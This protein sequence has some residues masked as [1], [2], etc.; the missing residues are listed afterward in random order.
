M[1]CFIAGTLIAIETGFAGIESIKPGDLVL[2][3]NADTMESGYK[4][5]LKNMYERQELVHIIAG[6]EESYRHRIIQILCCRKR[7]LLMP[8][9]FVSEVRCW[10]QAQSA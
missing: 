5:Y 6:G 9:S 4:R 2:S 1:K 8:V 3:T 7:D 10:M